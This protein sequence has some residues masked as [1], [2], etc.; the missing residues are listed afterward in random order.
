MSLLDAPGVSRPGEIITIVEI[1]L[2][3]L[4]PVNVLKTILMFSDR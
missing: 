2:K 4:L 3:E 1:M